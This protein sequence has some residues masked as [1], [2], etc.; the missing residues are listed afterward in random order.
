MSRGKIA[1]SIL[2]VP[3]VNNE[4]EVEKVTNETEGVISCKK[5][6]SHMI[7]RTAT[8]GEN[9]GEQFYHH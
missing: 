4:I 3:I 6:G 9:K 7:L 2:H 1:E 8:R 5:C